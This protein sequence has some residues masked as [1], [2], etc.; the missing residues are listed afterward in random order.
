MST[1]YLQL[2]FLLLFP[3]EWLFSNLPGKNID[4][5]TSYMSLI[6]H[7]YDYSLIWSSFEKSKNNVNPALKFPKCC[8]YIYVEFIY[9]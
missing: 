5:K 6:D 9:W 1:K 2:L 7:K 4:L 8:T 3:H